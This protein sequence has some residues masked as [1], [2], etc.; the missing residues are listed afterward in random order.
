MPIELDDIRSDPEQERER[1]RNRNR[2]ERYRALR[3]DLNLGMEDAGALI[4][5]SRIA[6]WWWEKRGREPSQDSLSRLHKVTGK[7]YAWLRGE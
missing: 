3:C 4:G 1:E 5:V 2:R 7:D 6:W